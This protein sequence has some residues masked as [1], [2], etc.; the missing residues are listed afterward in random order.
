MQLTV[1]LYAHIRAGA[2]RS[3]TGDVEKVLGRPP[4]DF[5]DYTRTAAAQ[6]AWEN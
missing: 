2:L 3:V 1:G 6:G 5:A 4:R